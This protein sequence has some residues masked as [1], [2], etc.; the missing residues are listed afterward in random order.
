MADTPRKRASLLLIAGG[1]R[2]AI[3][4]IQNYLGGHLQIALVTTHKNKATYLKHWRQ[5]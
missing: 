5:T 3:L 2:V 1:A 4:V